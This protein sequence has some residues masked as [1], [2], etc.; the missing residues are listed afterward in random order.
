VASAAASASPGV[1]PAHHSDAL[2]PGAAS[3]I[4]KTV[5]TPPIPPIPDIVLMADTTGSMN[6]SIANV[7]T[8]A[9]SIVNQVQSAQPGARFA[10]AEYKDDE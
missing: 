8:N 2:D 7:R 5:E 4:T 3:T 9:A 1:T 10:V 6:D